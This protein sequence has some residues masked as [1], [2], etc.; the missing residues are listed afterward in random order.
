MLSNSSITKTFWGIGSND[1]QFNQDQTV[2]IHTDHIWPSCCDLEVGSDGGNLIFLKSEA[3]DVNE[4]VHCTL[5]Y[6]AGISKIHLISLWHNHVSR[7]NVTGVM[8]QGMNS[9]C[10]G[11]W[12]KAIYRVGIWYLYTH[13]P[14]SHD[15]ERIW[16]GIRANSEKEGAS[17]RAGCQVIR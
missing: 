15:T 8:L 16:Q 4:E 13:L 14:P 17:C 10:I 5:H 9:K 7:Y 6:R 12:G 3:C 1:S 11:Q 2:T